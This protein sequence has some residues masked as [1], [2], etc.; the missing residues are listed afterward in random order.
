MNPELEQKLYFK[1]P[2][3][4][5]DRTKDKTESCMFWGLEVGDGWYDLLDIL[6]E[7][8]THTYT[9]SINIDEED[10]KRLSISPY[11]DRATGKNNY[12]FKIRA[13]EVVA[14][15]VKEKFGE[16]CFYYYL[17]YDEANLELVKTGKY[18]E[19]DVANKRYADYIDGIVHF[20][21][22]ASG[23]TCEVSGTEGETM[24]RGGWY[25]TINKDVAKTEPYIGYN[26]PAH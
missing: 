13:P 24:I 25:K 4:F 7:A 3:I 14:V 6:C 2:L 8:L 19:L 26:P 5:R 20:A 21:A 16:L 9:S 15:Q 12:Y 1:Y 17:N 23:R 22:I 11:I 10:G 18:P